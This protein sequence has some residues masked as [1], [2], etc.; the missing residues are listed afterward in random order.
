MP[1]IADSLRQAGYLQ[2]GVQG[3]DSFMQDLTK[4]KEQNAFN[5]LLGQAHDQIANNFQKVGSIPN[6]ISPSRLSD[7]QPPPNVGIGGVQNVSG[8][9]QSLSQISPPQQGNHYAEMS[10]LEQKQKNLRALADV[11]MKSSMFQN[12]SPEQKQSAIMGLQTFAQG[13]ETPMA[14]YQNLAVP[15]TSSLY[16]FNETNPS[17]APQ[18]IQ[19]GEEKEPVKVETPLDAKGNPQVKT[20][21]DQ[22]FV[23]VRTTNDRGETS[24]NWKPLPKGESPIPGERLQFEMGK[25]N[26]EHDPN[27]IM[28]NAQDNIAAI[29][30]Q[31]NVKD[32]K[33]SNPGAYTSLMQDRIKEVI[34]LNAA[35]NQAAALD[36]KSSKGKKN[37]QAALD[38]NIKAYAKK[39]N[40]SEDEARSYVK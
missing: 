32:L 39:W 23:L 15:S 33:V 34:K 30:E 31:L 4:Q 36:K 25:Y 14:Q 19:K 12:L 38:E 35:K 22:K 13:S 3:F 28:K 20:V 18:L 1:G 40:I 21:G 10:P 29:D 9:P 26:K 27:E 24:D 6:G 5:S 8:H 2:P 17:E 16:R 11:M 37:D 7:L